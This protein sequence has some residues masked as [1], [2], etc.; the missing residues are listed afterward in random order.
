M[1]ERPQAR[2]Q[3]HRPGVIVRRTGAYPP[4]DT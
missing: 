4:E 1:P 2:G 3:M